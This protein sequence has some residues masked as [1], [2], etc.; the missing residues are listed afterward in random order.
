MFF[1]FL[2][3]LIDCWTR[4]HYNYCFYER[5]RQHLPLYSVYEWM[6]VGHVRTC[7]QL[8]FFTPHIS[9]AFLLCVLFL[10]V[11]VVW[12][13]CGGCCMC[14][15]VRV[16]FGLFF[17]FFCSFS[18]VR[19]DRCVGCCCCLCIV[20]LRLLLHY[21]LFLPGGII[22]SSLSSSSSSCL[23]CYMGCECLCVVC[24]YVCVCLS[25]WVGGGGSGGVV[26]MGDISWL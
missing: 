21:P 14:A 19:F 5:L 8:F 13:W 15:C 3:W 10:R 16:C 22:P 9:S 2:I 11:W 6:C 17:S 20:S 1:C 26:A 7:L 24:V 4:S 12:G 23:L 18:F 25:W